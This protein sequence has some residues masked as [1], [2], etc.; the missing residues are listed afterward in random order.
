MTFEEM[1]ALPP[2]E[3]ERVIKRI[4]SVR[5]PYKVT[6]YSAVYG[7]GVTKLARE[8]GMTQ[9]EAQELLKA[10]WERNWAVD[11][12]SKGQYVKTLKDGS[13]WLKNP[14]S[15]FYYSLRYDK[16]RF[17]TLNQGLGVYIFDLWV[18]NMRKL[19]V[20]V[21][22]QYHDEVLFSIPKGKEKETEELLKKAMDKVNETLKLNVTVQADAQFGGSYDQCH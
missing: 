17:S 12:L 13:M 9:K 1:K 3:Q 7:V 21:S 11:K 20:T 15:G 6:N 14:V 10:Y 5:K 18:A 2:E 8:A 22:L 4:K 16:D 19:G